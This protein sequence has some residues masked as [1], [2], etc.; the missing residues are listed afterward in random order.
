[1]YGGGGGASSSG[2]G[3]VSG[4]VGGGVNGSG[5]GGGR[6]VARKCSGV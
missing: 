6:D 1:M 4:S 2:S 5:I 3:G